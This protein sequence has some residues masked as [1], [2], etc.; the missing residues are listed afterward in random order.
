MKGFPLFRCI[1]RKVA[2]CTDILIEA[3]SKNKFNYIILMLNEW[4]S[5]VVVKKDDFFIF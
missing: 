4:Y 5:D 1:F 3:N 2:T